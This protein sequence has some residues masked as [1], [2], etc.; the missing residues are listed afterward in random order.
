M[1]KYIY[2]IIIII[3]Y[4]FFYFKQ[5]RI[6]LFEITPTTFLVNL[7][8][9]DI[10][11]NLQFFINFFN[12]NCPVELQKLDYYKK[13]NIEIPKKIR[14]M[15][16]NS[17]SY[18]KKPYFNQIYSRPKMWK[19]FLTTTNY[20]WLLKPCGFN[21]G[22]GIQ[23]F[24]NLS[25]LEKFIAEYYDGMDEKTF[26]HQL[27]TEKTNNNEKNEKQENKQDKK[28]KIVENLEKSQTI[29]EEK[30][31]EIVHEKREET[32]EEGEKE[33]NPKQK[34]EGKKENVIKLHTFVIQKYVERP[35]LINSRK[36]D[37]RVWALATHNLDVYFFRYKLIYIFFLINFKKREGYIRTASENFQID[38][39]SSN[40]HF[41]HLTNNAVQKYSSNY[42]QFEDGNQL[43]FEFFEVILKYKKKKNYSF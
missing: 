12:R 8:K 19:S 43:S 27:N 41:I 24:M 38:S 22:R 23:L 1:S 31:E 25:Q 30:K 28:E 29:I 42:G 3:F 15:Y 40:N 17:S 37:I 33:N 16:I 4:H 21:R 35:F 7:E 39:S 9:D 26:E 14:Y 13:M 6:N 10:E 2:I 5:N 18:D 34:C 36:F 32:E 20:L 11:A